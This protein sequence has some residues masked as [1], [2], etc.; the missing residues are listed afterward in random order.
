ME[1]SQ[2]DFG[3]GTAAGP[4]PLS[5]LQALRLVRR[6][7]YHAQ[8]T[9]RI[10]GLNSADRDDLRQ[11]ISLDILL[12][13]AAFDPS[14]SS[15]DTFVELVAGH[16]ALRHGE[17]VIRTRSVLQSVPESLGSSGEA[18]LSI[19]GAKASTWAMGQRLAFQ[20]LVRDIPEVLPLLM[21]VVRNQPDSLSQPTS[22]STAWRRKHDL[23]CLLLLH[24]IDR[25]P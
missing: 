25:P 9:A 23:R 2:A 22:R 3:G 20:Q 10:R 11:D 5:R 7:A 13:L 1:G 21:T 15:F 17:R 19:A 12:R 6:A 8:R 14:R 16:A 18:A 24:G 4:L